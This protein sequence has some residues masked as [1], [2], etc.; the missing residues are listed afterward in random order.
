MISSTKSADWWPYWMQGS[1][2]LHINQNRKT[3]ETALPILS[4]E[5]EQEVMLSNLH[6]WISIQQQ[7]HV[8]Q[9]FFI[10]WT[11]S[12]FSQIRSDTCHDNE[13]CFTQLPVRYR[14]ATQVV[15]ADLAKLRFCIVTIPEVSLLSW[16]LMQ[17]QDP[18]LTASDPG[19]F[20]MPLPLDSQ[21]WKNKTEIFT[22]GKQS[23]F[24]S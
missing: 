1:C 19:I 6:I 10:S 15:A 7:H 17:V 9:K 5:A 3:S 8:A 20:E 22:I 2:T 23:K 14:E 16:S 24:H 12:Q 11:N 4:K 21:S 13:K 18:E